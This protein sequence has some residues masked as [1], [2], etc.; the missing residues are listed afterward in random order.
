MMSSYKKTHHTGNEIVSTNGKKGEN[1]VEEQTL[2]INKNKTY[3]EHQCET[4]ILTMLG[5]GPKKRWK[6]KS[7][8]NSHGYLLWT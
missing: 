5:H 7:T 1:Q 8:V 2:K 3:K 4:N 6:S